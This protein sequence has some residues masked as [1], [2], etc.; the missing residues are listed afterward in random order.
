M[1]GWAWTRA[2]LRVLGGRA[3]WS[4]LTVTSLCPPA[5]HVASAHGAHGAHGAHESGSLVH[6]S[7]CA[8]TLR[9]LTSPT[10]RTDSVLQTGQRTI[11]ALVGRAT[12]AVR[13]LPHDDLLILPHR[14]AGLAR[15]GPA[16]RIVLPA[17][18]TPPGLTVVE[19]GR[20]SAIALVID[21][22]LAV[23]DAATGRARARV[24]LGLQ[25]LG[26][27]AA[28]A[29][30]AGG[31]VYLVGQP[32]DTYAAVLEA[33]ALDG[34]GGPRILWR[35]QLGLTHAGLWTG[36]ASRG[37]LAV[38]LPDAHDVGGTVELLD[39]RRG[40]VAREVHGEVRGVYALP[41]P[42]VAADLASDRIVVQVGAALR[43]YTLGEGRPVGAIAGV[44]P[45]AVVP[46]RGL[47]AFIRGDE[48]V[49]ATT[50]ALLP[51]ARVT[52]PGVTALAAT[53]DGAALLVGRR[54]SLARLGLDGCRGSGRSGGA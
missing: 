49:L 16:V 45:V 20:G 46:A 21:G 9:A 3:L 51:V 8:P 10:G 2:T 34:Q 33:L 38:Y 42:P 22:T 24:S 5:V 17:Y 41:G 44:G 37:R 53:A 13:F 25:A 30:S 31:R 48:L 52:L 7:R 12:S 4:L 1:S 6:H 11:V 39:E 54:D 40:E 18:T 36:H 15:S 27:P 35:A 28:V 47:V 32:R 23:F 43:A 29:A 19:T 50:R 14:S 26:W